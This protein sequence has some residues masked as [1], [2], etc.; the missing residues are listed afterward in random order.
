MQPICTL[1]TPG[2]LAYRRPVIGLLRVVGLINAAVWF[3]A[4]VFFLWAAEP[5]LTQSADIRQLLEPRNYPY[6]SVALGQLVA[7]RLFHL[8]V[9]CSVLALL[10]LTAEWLYLGKYPQRYW[11]AL[12]LALSLAGLLQSFWLQPRLQSLHHQQFAATSAQREQ[13]R[14]TFHTWQSLAH[15]LNL[16][17]ACGLGLYLWRVA[18][19]ADPMRFV[20][21]SK[22][23]S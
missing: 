1:G 7:V 8:Y 20:G 3:G 14:R 15:G 19:P 12:V 4:T 13:E 10:H 5:A 6:Y 22:F 16:V 11:L 18:N 9:V 21:T 17:L 23:R 2:A